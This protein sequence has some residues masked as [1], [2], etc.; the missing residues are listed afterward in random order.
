MYN[1]LG[2]LVNDVCISTYTSPISCLHTKTTKTKGFFAQKSKNSFFNSLRF[3]IVVFGT[4]CIHML[5]IST[6][7]VSYSKRTL[8]EENP[9]EAVDFKISFKTCTRKNILNSYFVFSCTVRTHTIHT[10]PVQYTQNN[11][12]RVSHFLS[13]QK[14]KL[15]VVS[16][17]LF[18]S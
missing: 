17:E 12:K 9:P 16:L 8:G 11:N 3:L 4:K 6:C 14:N 1:F 18:R 13:I 7:R 10:V 2:T 15:F 5:L